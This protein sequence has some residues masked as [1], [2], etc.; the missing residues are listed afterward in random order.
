MKKKYI[1]FAAFVTGTL[2]WYSCKKTEQP[3][4]S[5]DISGK[6]ALF[7]DLRY[8]PQRFT[9]EAGRDTVIL[10]ADSTV[11]HF[12]TN[13]FKDASGNIVSSGNIGIELI[14]MYTPGDMVLN[15][16]TTAMSDGRLLE[17]GGQVKISA[18]MNG[19]V[20]SANRYGIGF[21]SKNGNGRAMSLYFGDR[22]NA[23]SIVTWTEGGSDTTQPSSG[24]LYMFRECNSFDFVNCDRLESREGKNTTIQ[25][26]MPD[27]SFSPE[28]TQIYVIEP[29]TNSATMGA[30][31]QPYDKNTLSFTL[32][33]HGNLVAV[34]MQ[35]VLVV[36]AKKEDNYYFDMQSGTITEN[37]TVKMNP[38]PETRYNI[39]ARLSGIQ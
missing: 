31:T 26:V 21:R 25:V 20:L 24:F 34:G 6:N 10:G 18:V 5:N 17:S 4:E 2:V 35:Y 38:S 33:N 22:K 7:S 1:L 8:T 30:K 19:K 39:K 13:S 28:N 14:E 12:Y 16:A 27:A 37:M 3:A 15:R 32:G 9:V 23:D 29:K 11:L 36:I